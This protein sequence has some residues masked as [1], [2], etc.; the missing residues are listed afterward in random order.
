MG[1][2]VRTA[3]MDWRVLDWPRVVSLFASNEYHGFFCLTN[4]QRQRTFS[5]MHL[6]IGKYKAQTASE[7]SQELGTRM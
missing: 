3:F 5:D 2:S 7:L 1:D 4:D 6:A